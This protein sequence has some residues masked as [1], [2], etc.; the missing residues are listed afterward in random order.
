MSRQMWKCK[1]WVR[2][3]FLS[4][5]LLPPKSF[6]YPTTV[7]KSW[8]WMGLILESLE[9]N[10]LDSWISGVEWAWILN[11][12]GWMGLILE[13]PSSFFSVLRLRLPLWSWL[14]LNPNCS[15]YSYHCLPAG[16]EWAWI[17]LP[18]NSNNSTHFWLSQC[19]SYDFLLCWWKGFFGGGRGRG[20]GDSFGEIGPKS[21]YLEGKKRVEFAILR[22]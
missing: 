5:S 14:G 11:L 15:S 9:L 18:P 6:P 3:T 21:P 8:S 16:V 2:F 4:K 17:H 20:G 1:E 10:G 22:T 19:P 13:S 12:W 7:P